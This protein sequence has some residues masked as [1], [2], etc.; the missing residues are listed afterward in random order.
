M[1]AWHR[2][3]MLAFDLET[4]GPEPNTARIVTAAVV[5]VDSTGI[6]GSRN[7]LVDPGIEIPEGASAIHG[8]T[9]EQ[10]RN[11]GMQPRTAV[12]EISDALA[13]WLG[14]GTPVI[15]F[16]AAYDFTVLDRECQ[17]H[18]IQ[19]LGARFADVAP[20]IDPFVIDKQVDRFRKGKRILTVTCEHYRV[21][22]TDAH[23]SIGDALGAA[24]I[25]FAL[26]ERYRALQID[27]MDL[28]AQ[29][30]AWRKE[31]SVGLAQYFARIGKPEPVNGEWPVQSTPLGWLPELT[32]DLVSS[33]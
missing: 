17:R 12:Q 2:E 8:I 25:A 14:H 7:W 13:D 23:S 27:L 11:E 21:S 6:V 16:N 5:I 18:F 3:P 24:R 28:H 9:T 29:Q 32:D 30:R 19:P 15:A 22:M 31:Q 26:A 10:A 33:Q 1:T 4:T 20:V